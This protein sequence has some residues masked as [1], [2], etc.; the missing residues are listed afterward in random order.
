LPGDDSDS[1]LFQFFKLF[2][3]RAGF[4]QLDDVFDGVACQACLCEFW[5]A[6]SPCGC[7]VVVEIFEE[8]FEADRDRL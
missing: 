6:G 4:T 8:G 5:C 1:E 7:E 3:G 2:L